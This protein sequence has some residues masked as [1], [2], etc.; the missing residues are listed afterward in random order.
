VFAN[1]P[2]K[3]LVEILRLHL[4]RFKHL[5]LVK[6]NFDGCGWTWLSRCPNLTE[7]AITNAP[8]KGV[9]DV[10]GTNFKIHRLKVSKNSK[11]VTAHWHFG[12]DDETFYFHPD[13]SS[14]EPY[15]EKPTVVVQPKVSRRTNDP[16]KLKY[17]RL[18]ILNKMFEDILKHDYD[19]D[20]DYGY[21]YGYDYDCD[22]DCDYGYDSDYNYDCYD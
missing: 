15:G 12:V 13:E 17:I 22:Y 18:N 5:E 20:S 6:W 9:C 16:Q 10:L 4:D 14:L 11:I 7:F 2:G 19:S 8:P 21:D 1:G 3:R